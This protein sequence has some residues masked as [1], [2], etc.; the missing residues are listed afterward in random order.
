MTENPTRNGQSWPARIATVPN[1][2]S[3]SRLVLLPVI[4]YFLFRHQGL[5]ALTVMAISWFTDGLD[6][7]LARRFDQVSDLGRVLD[8]VVDKVWVGTVLVTLTFTRG[9]PL[10][11]AAAVILRDILI[12]LGSSVIMRVRG[13]FVSSD[14]LGKI[15]GFAFA[16][17]MVFYTLSPPALEGYRLVIDYSVGALI[18][19]SFVNYFTVFLRKMGRFRLPDEETRG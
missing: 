6:G 3:L 9:L 10:A 19:A 2:L 18:V 16:V 12:L 15:T 8:H 1:I 14:V 13:H 17:L 5:A 11:I 7:Y 4:L